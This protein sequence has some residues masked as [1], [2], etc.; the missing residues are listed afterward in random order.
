MTRGARIGSAGVHTRRAFAMTMTLIMAWATGRRGGGAG[1]VR[2]RRESRGA[3]NV[4]SSDVT[5]SAPRERRATDVTRGAQL[6]CR[7]AR[8]SSTATLIVARA[9]GSAGAGRSTRQRQE[10]SCGCAAAVSPAG[11]RGVARGTERA[12][13][14]L[15]RRHS[16]ASGAPQ[17]L[18]SL[19]SLLVNR[20]N[21]QACCAVCGT[22]HRRARPKPLLH[23]AGS[24]FP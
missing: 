15:G 17:L 21:I 12:V 2:G 9:A 8:R 4:I 11:Q 24:V 5:L 3:R 22:H 23:A 19:F 7:D 18:R 16:G 6:L 1:A 20:R 14:P 13:A 10:M